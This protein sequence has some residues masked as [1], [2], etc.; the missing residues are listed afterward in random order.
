MNKTLKKIM[1]LGLTFGAMLALSACGSS[2]TITIAHKNYT[3]Q[4]LLGQMASVFLEDKGFD[5]KVS[6]LG[7]TALCFNAVKSGDV[8]FYM[9]YTGTLYGAVLEQEEAMP[10]DE[11]Y[12]YV[13][14]ELED[15]HDVTILKDLGFNNTYVLSVTE[16]KAKELNIKTISDLIP[17]SNDFL[18]G[19]DLEF[20]SRADGLIG[21]TE[22]YEGLKFKNV[23]SMDQ[24]LTYKALD[25][26]DIDVNVSYSTDGRIAKF[27]LV[28]LEDD[29][30]FFPSYYVVPVM[31]QEFADENEEVVEALLELEG[32]WT[33]EDMQKYNLLVDEGEDAKKVATMM[34][35]DKGLIG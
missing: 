13:K 3:E 17:H 16:E 31:K 6:E 12:D 21:L 18:I 23:K 19:S 5:T 32:H 4:R 29:K 2:E 11:T 20:A 14:T 9:D 33:E 28:N 8:D 15:K 1:G 24:G 7:G 26:G 35:E 27:G 25:S 34:L 10:A 30:N 22:M